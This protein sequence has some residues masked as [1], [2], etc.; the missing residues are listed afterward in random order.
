MQHVTE[1]E[2]LL[3]GQPVGQLARS[4]RGEIWFEYDDRWIRS[5]FAGYTRSFQGLPACGF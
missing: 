1:L 3:S 4:A 2:V 5:G